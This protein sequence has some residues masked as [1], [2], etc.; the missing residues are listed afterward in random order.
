LDTEQKSNVVLTP[1][2]SEWAEVSWY[3]SDADQQDLHST[4]CQLNLRMYDVTGID[5]SY[6]SPQLVQQYTCELAKHQQYVAIPASDRDYIME[7]GYVTAGDWVTLARSEIVRIFSPIS[8]ENAVDLPQTHDAQDYSN[9]VFTSRTPK[10]AYVSWQLSDTDKQALQKAGSQLA[11]RLYDV[12]GLDL[13]YQSPQL[14]Q[15]YACELAINEQYIVIGKSD[16]DYI[17]EIGYIIDGDRWVKLAQSAIV[18]V[19]SRPEGDFWFI[20]DAELIIHGATDPGA[21]VNIAGNPVKLKSDGT[22]HLRIPFSENFIDYL[23]TAVAANGEETKT[24]HK[25]FSQDTP[26]TE[27]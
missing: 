12:T 27:G 15:Q 13:S 11:L 26:K 17:T 1:G 10:W 25:K 16:R 2:T 20:A 9:V 7:I 5:L 14:V 21:T 8:T 22:F 4:G 23:M 3:V 6:Q 18:R 19:F 24:I